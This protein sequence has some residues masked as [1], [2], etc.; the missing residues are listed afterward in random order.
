[1]KCVRNFIKDTS[2]SIQV[3]ECLFPL[4]YAKRPEKITFYPIRCFCKIIYQPQV[5][6]GIL[7]YDLRKQIHSL[8]C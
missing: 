1:M 2:K 7:N 8:K 3:E 6:V 4:G 5:I